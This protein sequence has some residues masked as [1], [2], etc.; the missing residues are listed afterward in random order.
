MVGKEQRD[1]EDF[2]LEFTDVNVV[3]KTATEPFFYQLLSANGSR[4]YGTL[5]VTIYST[6]VC[7]TEHH[8]HRFL[9]V[10]SAL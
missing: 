8:F 2:Y 4:K 10:S 7:I 6:F 3:S 1:N 9:L 5:K